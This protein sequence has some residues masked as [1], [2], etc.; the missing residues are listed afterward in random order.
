MLHG[1][2]ERLVLSQ[3]TKATEPDTAPQKDTLSKR[4]HRQAV[5]S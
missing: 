5:G 3:T 1:G 2:H 4:G